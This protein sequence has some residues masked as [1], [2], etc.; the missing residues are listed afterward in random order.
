MISECNQ[1]LIH[2]EDEEKL[3]NEISRIIVDYAEKD[4]QK[5]VRPV[6]QM[7][8]EEGYLKKLNITW[9]DTEQGRGPTGTAIRTG[10]SSI[11]RNIFT[12]PNFA[13]WRAEATK[14]G[15]ASSMA[16]PLIS[17]DQTFGALNIYAAE[18]EAFEEEEAKLLVELADDLAYGVAVLRMRVEHKN[19]EEELEKHRQH[20]EELVK[21][22]TAE[23]EE[24]NK[25]LKHFNSVFIDREFR[26]K[27]LKDRVKE[28]EGMKLSRK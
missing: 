5:T 1:A 14:R 11:A 4:E 7:G 27:E 8:Y 25:E 22:R 17:G 21:E 2:A 26:I 23:L 13:P 16:L 24:K 3:L 20:L 10:K 9:A 28:L 19:A 6:A 12:D 18:P 15:Y